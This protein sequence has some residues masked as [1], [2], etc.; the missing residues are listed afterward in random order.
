MRTRDKTL[1]DYGVPPEDVKRLYALC[2]DCRF[3]EELAEAVCAA[4]AAGNRPAIYMAL[5]ERS[6]YEG[7]SAKSAVYCTRKDFY[8]YKRKAAAEFYKRLREN[9][10]WEG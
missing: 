7:V 6:G 10:K 5:S 4:I 9:G 8:G 3:Q 1:S 2:A